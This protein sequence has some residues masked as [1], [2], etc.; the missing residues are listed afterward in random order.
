[1]ACLLLLL[2]F[3][4][5]S[6]HSSPSSDERQRLF[7][8]CPRLSLFSVRWKCNLAGKVSAM[9]HLSKWVHLKCS[10]LPF[11]RLRALGSSHSWSFPFYCIPDSSGDTTPTSTE[12][13]SSNSSSLY[14]STAQSVS[15]NAPPHPRLYTSY[16]PSAHFVS[17]PSAPHHHLMLLSIF[18]HLLV[19][20]SLDF[21][22]ALQWNAGGL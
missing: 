10:V 18:L 6:S 21:F 5:P 13:S 7:Q 11:S 12:N 3:S 17:S 2:P 9:L 20:L 14:T 19:P 16:P 15:A 22:S 1:M 4:C 8:P